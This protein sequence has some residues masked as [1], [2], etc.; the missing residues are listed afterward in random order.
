VSARSNLFVPAR[1][2]INRGIPLFCFPYAGGS[3]YLFMDWVAKLQPE[4]QMVALQAPGHGVRFSERPHLSIEQMV[5]EVLANFPVNDRPFAFYG[6]SLGAVIAF[7]IARELRRT[8]RPQPCH[9]FVGGARPPH[10]GPIEPHIHHL[11][12]QDFIDGVQSRYSGIPDAVLNEPELLA[13]LLPALR[14]DFTAYET[15]VHQQEA[16]LRCP[17]SA[18]VG[19]SDPL[20]DVEAMSN[21]ESYTSADFDLTVMPGDH[22]FLRESSAALTGEIRRKLAA[23]LS[24]AGKHAGEA[25]E[26][27]SFDEKRTDWE[28]QPLSRTP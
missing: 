26:D 18:F 28:K 8:G 21:W 25:E 17:I 23:S 24:R 2:E 7:E 15:Y 20:V 10:Y 27:L 22:F 13:I 4:I 9:L 14:A 19:E 1:L 5:V 11:A 12:D 16:P 3:P 6:H